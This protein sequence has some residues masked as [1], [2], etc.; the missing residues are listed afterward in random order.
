MTG[1]TATEPGLIPASGVGF[2]VNEAIHR[3]C[4]FGT[5]YAEAAS[6]GFLNCVKHLSK[7]RRFTMLPTTLPFLYV[8]W[9]VVKVKQNARSLGKRPDENM[10]TKQITLTNEFA[11]RECQTYSLRND[12]ACH[13]LRIRHGAP[14][15]A[16]CF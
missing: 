4:Q 3:C 2:A 7:R 12:N 5:A 14:V 15:C 10:S 8:R 13:L 1:L 9:M 11:N 6:P 16:L